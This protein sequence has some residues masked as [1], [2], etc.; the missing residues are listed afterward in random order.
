MISDSG[1]AGALNCSTTFSGSEASCQSSSFTNI[2]T[3]NFSVNWAGNDDYNAA[4]T[5]TT[6]NVGQASTVVESVTPQAAQVG[7]TTTIT[8]L[9]IPFPDG[10]NVS[11]SDNDLQVTGCSAVPVNSSTGIA[12]C[13]TPI[14]TTADA[15]D[16]VSAT[17][18]GDGN[19]A[20]SLTGTGNLDVQRGTTQVTVSAN[21]SPSVGSSATYSASVTPSAAVT[22]GGSLAFSD[23]GGKITDC[24]TVPVTSPSCESLTYTQVGSDQVTASFGGSTNW[25]PSSGETTFSVAQGQPDVSVSLSPANPTVGEQVVIT[26]AVSP[27]D[28]GGSVAFSGSYISGCATQPLNSGMAHCTTSVLSA[29]G[30]WTVTASYSGDTNYDE[31]GAFKTVTIAAATNH[32]HDRARRTRAPRRSRPTRSTQP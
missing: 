27:T 3:D 20:A 29:I 12:T 22:G 2:G 13:T 18:L 15:S 16:T 17:Y 23:T 32:G 4:S 11:F 14:L 31:L 7:Q 21:P 30:S 9:V 6:L 10:G 25:A 28:G 5:S 19:Y 1:Y 8:A 24:N 26:A